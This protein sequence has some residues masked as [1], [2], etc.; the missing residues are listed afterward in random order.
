MRLNYLSI[1]PIASY[2]AGFV[3]GRNLCVAA[4]TYAGENGEIKVNLG[5][6][7]ATRM[8]ALVA[9]EM[10]KGSQEIAQKL[11]AEVI[12]HAALPAPAAAVTVVQ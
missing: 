5:P 6:E 11:T 2:E 10:V 9:E 8:L 7:F 12:T 3:E 1:R 4:V